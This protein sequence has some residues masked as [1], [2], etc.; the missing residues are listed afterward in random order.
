MWLCFWGFFPPVAF[1]AFSLPSAFK[2]S[3]LNKHVICSLLEPVAKFPFIRIIPQFHA[4]CFA[5]ALQ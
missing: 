3:D 2:I 4:T 1:I 5:H